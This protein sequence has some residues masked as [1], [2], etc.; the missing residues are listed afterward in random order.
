MKFS[1]FIRRPARAAAPFAI[2]A[3]AIAVA[4]VSDIS[5]TVSGSNSR[6]QLEGDLAGAVVSGLHVRSD[7][8]LLIN[9]RFRSFVTTTTETLPVLSF[10]SP[11]DGTMYAA[12]VV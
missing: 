6:A 1:S 3:V 11:D 4:C 12:E 8:R 7:L 2:L 10:P 5:P 9:N